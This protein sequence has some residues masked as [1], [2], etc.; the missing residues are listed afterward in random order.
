MTELKSIS[1]E[2]CLVRPLVC[3]FLEKLTREDFQWKYAYGISYI[4]LHHI[5]YGA[6]NATPLIILFPPVFVEIR[7]VLLIYSFNKLFC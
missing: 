7:L 3:S 6:E 5:I 4:I 1:E 2:D